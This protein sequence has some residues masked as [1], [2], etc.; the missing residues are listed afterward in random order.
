MTDG[1]PDTIILNT[2]DGI[3]MQQQNNM[4]NIKGAVGTG[5]GLSTRRNFYIALAIVLEQVS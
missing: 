3:I 4:V 2:N 5:R 1:E